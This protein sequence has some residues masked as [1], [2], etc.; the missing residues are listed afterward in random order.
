MS[1]EPGAEQVMDELGGIAAAEQAAIEVGQVAVEQVPR[2]EQGNHALEVAV[3]Q[4]GHVEADQRA[5]DDD[6]AR[7]R[8]ALAP[9]ALDHRARRPPRARTPT[10]PD[11]DIEPDQHRDEA[12][13]HREAPAGDVVGVA[14]RQP[15]RVR[16]EQRREDRDRRHHGSRD[17]HAPVRRLLASSRS[18]HARFGRRRQRRYPCV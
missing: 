9:D 6:P 15:G 7:Q 4:V 3:R 1:L 18:H 10:R 11:Q 2:P 16:R 12:E 14:Q 13:H 5:A 17:Q 8:P